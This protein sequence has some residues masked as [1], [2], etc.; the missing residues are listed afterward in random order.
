[1]TMVLLLLAL[2]A[3]GR[4]DYSGQWV[5]NAAESDFGLIPPPQC[6][7]LKVAHREPE[8]ILEETRPDGSECGLRLRYTTDGAP[9]TYTA[10]N[11]RQQARLAWSGNALVI[12]RRGED[13]VDMRIEATL[14][15]DGRKLTRA[16]HVESPQGATDW[17]YVYD[18]V[19]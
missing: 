1:M 2:Q 11:A 6:R 19:P 18:R 7:G 4:A 12:Q 10:N 14:S 16:F 8:V 13:G 5:V 17:T 9:I 3:G 15:P